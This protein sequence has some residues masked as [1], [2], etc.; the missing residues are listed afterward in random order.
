MKANK[1]AY[2]TVA[3]FL[4]LHIV[5][6]SLLSTVTWLGKQAYCRWSAKK[7]S[8]KSFGVSQLF[9]TMFSTLTLRKLPDSH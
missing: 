6:E 1:D 2:M 5:P 3:F 9:I 8:E 4:V 7:Y